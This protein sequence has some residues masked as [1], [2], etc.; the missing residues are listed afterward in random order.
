MYS[1]GGKTPEEYAQ[2][3][4]LLWECILLGLAF[5]YSIGVNHVNFLPVDDSPFLPFAFCWLPNG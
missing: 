5:P 2:R 1:V 3:E 4:S